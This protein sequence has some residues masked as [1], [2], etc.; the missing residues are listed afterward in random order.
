MN[1]LPIGL[2]LYSLRED[3][4]SDPAGT[5]TRVAAMGYAGVE[6]AGFFDW[7]AA[8]VRRTL[9]DLSLQCCGAHIGIQTMLPDV[10]EATVEFHRTIGNRFLI[11]PGLPAEYTGSPANYRRTAAVFNELAEKLEPH[12]LYVG[13]HCHA[14]DFQPVEG[15][16]PWEILAENTGDRVVLQM[17]TGNCLAG[18]GDPVAYLRRYPGR[19][20][21][22]HLKA[23]YARQ[24]DALVGEDDQDYAGIF[25]A[26]ATVAGTEW[27]I[28]EQESYPVTPLESVQAC[29]ENL[30]KLG[31]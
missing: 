3:T 20:L 23:D 18:G 25:A 26:C 8:E 28:V 30:R 7:S 31:L 29:L 10:F 21:A 15:E 11:V 16:I 6:F 5:L 1:N 12:G 22:V 24:E 2:Q 13:Y 19:A 9:D 27:Y 17:D 4:A 14:G